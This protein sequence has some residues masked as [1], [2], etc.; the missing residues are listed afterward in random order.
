MRRDVEY[1]QVAG[2]NAFWLPLSRGRQYARIFSAAGFQARWILL[3]HST[4]PVLVV[5][6]YWFGEWLAAW[7][8]PHPPITA[9]D[10]PDPAIRSIYN[11]TP[12]WPSLWTMERFLAAFPASALEA[13]WRLHGLNGIRQTYMA[14]GYER[15]MVTVHRQARQRAARGISTRDWQHP[16][17]PPT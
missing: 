8:E 3:P 2:F 14:W 7:L 1:A 13:I 10:E 6:E 17:E 11:R 5:S 16:A 9:E 12:D 4:G 15:G